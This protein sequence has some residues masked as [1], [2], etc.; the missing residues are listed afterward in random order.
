MR[1]PM[2]RHLVFAIF[3]IISFNNAY[4]CLDDKASIGI[5]E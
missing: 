5:I 4:A 2:F 1:K 3:S